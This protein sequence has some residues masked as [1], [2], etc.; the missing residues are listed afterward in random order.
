[1]AI[2]NA[3]PSRGEYFED[4]AS[5]FHRLVWNTFSNDQDVPENALVTNVSGTV[6]QG[7]PQVASNSQVARYMRCALAE[8]KIAETLSTDVFQDTFLGDSLAGEDLAPLLT[9][10]RKLRN[11]RHTMQATIIKWQLVKVCQESDTA[12]EVASKASQSVCQILGP[13]LGDPKMRASAFAQ[14]LDRLFSEAVVL[15]QTIQ[16]T[17]T[18]AKVVMS[19][20]EELWN[21]TVDSYRE[22]DEI[23]RP[24]Q[25]PQSS[26]TLGLPG[27]GP[28]AVLFPQI[29]ADNDPSDQSDDDLIYPGYALFPTQSAFIAA[30]AERSAHPTMPTLRRSSTTDRRRWSKT[31]SQEG[32]AE[33]RRPTSQRMSTS[34][35]DGVQQK[36]VMGTTSDSEKGSVLSSV[37]GRAGPT[38]S[39]SSTR[40]RRSGSAA[41]G[42]G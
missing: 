21:Y 27:T 34:S 32:Q 25:D 31:K 41:H 42:G 17:R 19:L 37:L 14:E 6:H 10:M 12:R 9:A 16:R 2:T 18:H 3:R 11:G 13:W 7:I 30:R 20:E 22:Y 1:M 15:W 29:R 36:S 35:R 26:I 28:V 8:A 23:Q 5:N 38:A 39:V 4:L 24:E 33:A 40:S